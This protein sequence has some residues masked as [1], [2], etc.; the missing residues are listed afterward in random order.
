MQATMKPVIS[1]ASGN[2]SGQMDDI[3]DA[4]YIEESHIY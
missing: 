4:N 3:T 2:I 1:R